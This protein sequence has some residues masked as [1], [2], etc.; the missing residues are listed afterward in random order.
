MLGEMMV[1]GRGGPV[2][3]VQAFHLFE[4]AGPRAAMSGQ[5]MLWPPCSTAG[6][7]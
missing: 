4:R 1:N 3:R 6:T 5:S 2:D 7:V